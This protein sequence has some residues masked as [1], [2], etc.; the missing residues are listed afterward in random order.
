[1]GPSLTERVVVDVLSKVIFEVI[2]KKVSIDV[3][4]KRA[5]RGKCV[6][7]LEE[8]EE[9]YEKARRFVSDYIR[10]L[11]ALGRPPKSRRE[12]VRAWLK[13]FKE[14]REPHC[15]LSYPKWMYDRLT[16]LLGREEG[17]TLMRS[18]NERKW[19]LRVNTLRASPEKVV[20]ELERE[21]VEFEVDS[22]VWFLIKVVKSPKP[23]RLLNV[24]K[25]LQAIPQDKASVYTVLA[26]DPEPGDVVLDMT[27][28]PGMKTSLIIALTECRTKVVATD[29]SSKRVDSMRA[30]LRKL[31]GRVCEPEIVLADSIKPPLRPSFDKV[32]LDAPCSNSGAIHKDP[33]VKVNL[34]E[35]KLKYYS[36]LQE[37]LLRQ[38]LRLGS[39]VVYSTCSLFPEEGEEVVERVLGGDV[40]AKLI[41]PLEGLPSG[42]CSY[43]YSNYFTRFFPHIHESDGFFVAKFLA[44]G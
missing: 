31:V 1:M 26:L 15:L 29:I 6:R 16:N 40:E 38:A 13:G 22:R 8:R 7:T 4:F 3:A 12:L 5:C 21:G 11:C 10:L 23:V 14:P 32:L 41:K 9:L 35:G 24:V 34:T 17:E 42:Y 33:S 2:S 36:V 44:L 39:I 19:W 25:S 28:A 18:L 43:R 37:K 30:L 27:A 20:R